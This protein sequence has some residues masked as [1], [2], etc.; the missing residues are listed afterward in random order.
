MTP[1]PKIAIKVLSQDLASDAAAY[2]GVYC[3]R[4]SDLKTKLLAAQLGGVTTLLLGL[5]YVVQAAHWQAGVQPPL[6]L[7]AVAWLMLGLAAAAVLGRWR[8]KAHAYDE[9]AHEYTQMYNL[10][11]RIA[12]GE[13]DRCYGQGKLFNEELERFNRVRATVGGPAVSE[14]ELEQAR[15]NFHQ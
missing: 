14:R 4:A 13:Y 11:T 7:S 8:D 12:R 9:A 1:S 3:G 5:G 15:V 6:W 2:L 10:F